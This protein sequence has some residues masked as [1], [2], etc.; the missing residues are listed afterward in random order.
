VKDDVQ[1]GRKPEHDE[2]LTTLGL[3]VLSAQGGNLRCAHLGTHAVTL[4]PGIQAV[5]ADIKPGSN[6]C[7]AV[8]AFSYLLNRLNLE[9]F[10]EPCLLVHKHLFYLFKLRL[11]GAY[12][13]RSDSVRCR[14]DF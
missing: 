5:L 9:F 7:D 2:V 6:F 8:A 14:S 12:K 4:G 10:R 11:S 1:S 13:T 3:A